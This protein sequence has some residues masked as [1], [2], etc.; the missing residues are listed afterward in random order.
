[1]KSCVTLSNHIV[2]IHVQLDFPTKGPQENWPLLNS[3]TI[4]QKQK[5]QCWPIDNLLTKPGKMLKS[6]KSQTKAAFQKLSTRTLYPT[7]PLGLVKRFPIFSFLF[8]KILKCKEFSQQKS[9]LSPAFT[10]ILICLLSYPP[11]KVYLKKVF[12]NALVQCTKNI[13]SIS[14]YVSVCLLPSHLD[15]AELDGEALF[16]TVMCWH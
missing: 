4:G 6:I 16:S 14:R 9:F 10:Y 5:E 3:I 2:S 1:M 12:L 7:Y 15:L 8:L 13:V 11:K